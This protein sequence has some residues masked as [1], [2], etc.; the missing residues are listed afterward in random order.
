M[1]G[2]LPALTAAL[3]LAALAATAVA[4]D[5]L[6]ATRVLRSQTLIGPA[7]VT[8]IPGATPGALTD[9]VQAVGLETRIALYP[10]RPIRADHLGPPALVERNGIV[11]LRYHR[12][13]LFIAAEGRALDRAGKGDRVRVMN[14]SSRTIVIGTVRPDGSVEVGG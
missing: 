3:I 2:L 11:T 8:L 13:G 9:P 5:T 14:L 4:Q 10:G 1:R 6:V 7:D 12:G